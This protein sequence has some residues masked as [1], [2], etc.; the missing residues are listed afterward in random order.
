M[1]KEVENTIVN[2]SEAASLKGSVEH[3][4]SSAIPVHQFLGVPFAEPPV[5]KL[6]FKPPVA[7]QLWTGVRD[8]LKFGK[9]LYIILVSRIFLGSKSLGPL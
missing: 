4:G 9:A 2:L 6:R 1:S 7:V 8:A 5:G 3:H